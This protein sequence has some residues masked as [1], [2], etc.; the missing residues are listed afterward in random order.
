M[1]LITTLSGCKN[2]TQRANTTD[3]WHKIKNRG[4]VIIGLDDSF[5]P[6]GFREKNGKLVGY[7][8]DLA[9]AVFK[10]LGLKVSFQ[11]IDWSMKET[12]LRNGTIDLIWNGYTKTKAREKTVAFSHAYLK[13]DQVLV[14][15]KKNKINVAKDMTDKI[16]GLQS[17][18]SG[19][20]EFNQ[21]PQILKK[22][23]KQSVQ[24]DTFTNAFLDLNNNRIQGLLIDSVYANY[25]IAHE[26]DSSSYNVSNI[27]FPS[28]DFAVGMRKGDKTLKAKIN[29]VLAQLAADGT[30][31]KITQKWFGVNDSVSFKDVK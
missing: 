22:Y 1:L 7:D 20:S 21:E 6:M 4:T 5:V 10:R 28:E 23:V 16:L 27:G 18:S 8:I 19:Y 15:K 25:Y 26:K 24:Y 11:T 17:G 3:T 29:H 31:N 13:N 14:S 30:L 2:V 12:E 9:R